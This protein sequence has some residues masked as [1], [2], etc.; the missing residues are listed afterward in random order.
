[1]SKKK[2]ILLSFLGIFIV[3]AIIATIALTTTWFKDLYFNIVALTVSADDQDFDDLRDRYVVSLTGGTG[4]DLNDENIQRNIAD[5]DAAANENW[6]TMNKGDD[7][8]TLWSDID[9]SDDVRANDGVIGASY[10]R[11]QSMALAY[12]TYGSSLEGNQDLLNDIIYGLEWLYT[13]KYNE[14]SPSFNQEGGHGWYKVIG[15][16]FALLR[17]TALIYDDLSEDQIDKYLKTVDHFCPD[18][19]FWIWDKS[20]GG[21]RSNQCHI[22]ILRGILGYDKSKIIQGADALLDTYKYVETGDGFYEDGSFI[23]HKALVAN[24]S[25]GVELLRDTVFLTYLLSDSPFA[26]TDPISDHVYDWVFN[27]FEPIIYRGYTFDDSRGRGVATPSKN[28]GGLSSEIGSILLLSQ[29]NGEYQDRLQSLAKYYL[30][31][32][33]DFFDYQS[34][35]AINMGQKLL[36]DE[37]VT[38]R[39]DITLYKQYPSMD[40]IAYQQPNYGV[41]ISMYSTR[42][43]NYETVN[44]MNL[45]GW[46]QG[47]GWMQILDNDYYS[48]NDNYWNTID[49]Y[50]I[51]G[52][53]EVKESTIEPVTNN[54]SPWVGGTDMDSIYGV[55]GMEFIPEGVD[56]SARKSWFIFDD[57]IVCLGSDINSGSGEVETIVE[58]KAINENGDNPLLINGELMPNNI[59]WSQTVNG[60]VDNAY[61]QSNTDENLG[62]GYY[63]PEPQNITALRET[64]SGAWDDISIPTDYETAAPEIYSRNYLSLAIEHGENPTGADYE[65]TVLPSTTSDRVEEY[66]AN[67]DTTVIV[68][69]PEVQAVKENNLNIIGANFWTD[70]EATAD[71]ITSQNK[72]SVMV[73]DNDD[74]IEISVS[75]PTQ[76]G[77]KIELE[78]NSSASEVISC[79]DEIKVTQTSPTIKLEVDTKDSMGQSFKVVLDK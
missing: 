25:Y 67:P 35:W 50:R 55:T 22:V 20:T 43:F 24:G 12:R 59:G 75:D 3:V 48:Y 79:D 60:I 71:I 41:G 47:D 46:H 61:I 7:I 57:E 34:I 77:D 1:M 78:I 62:T 58:N 14:N 18:P 49:S 29:V 39:G 69:S 38:P 63:F 16:P 4:Y 51:P 17:T 66:S 31:Y 26:I 19:T 23:Q 8:T 68:N 9:Y 6:S 10:G 70:S 37:S 74:E 42:T 44:D 45:R 40:F 65:Y 28:S 76:L 53:T 21:N 27:G 72:A 5:I 36:E 54:G 56:I 52:T 13:N 32:T 33:P 64:R 2:K 73:K 11:L 30:M 15:T